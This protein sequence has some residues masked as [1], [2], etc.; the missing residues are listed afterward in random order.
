VRGVSRFIPPAIP[1]LKA[2][3][4]I[5]E[6]W[7]Y[8]LKLDGYRVVLVKAGQGVTIY[9]KNGSEF[10]RRFP[11]IAAAALGLPARSFIIDGELIAADAQGQPDF[12]A[13]LFAVRRAPL[14]VY[15]FDLL[16]IQD[17]DIRNDPLVQRRARLKA[18]LERAK[19]NVVRFS[20]SFNDPFALMA[21][22]ERMGFE[23]IVSK[24]KDAPY[25]SG[26]R[27]GWIK[28]KCEGWKLANRDRGKLFEKA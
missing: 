6:V 20:E 24:R 11:S 3:P 25:R 13:L 8:E 4:P 22:C 15:A 17:R 16:E 10:T 21:E 18:L 5:G 9:S 14:C 2:S 27:C 19:C 12:R 23:G 1:V 7:Q 26:T 28:T